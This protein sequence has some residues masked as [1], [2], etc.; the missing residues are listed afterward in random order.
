MIVDIKLS[1][2]FNLSELVFSPEAVRLGIDNST[3]DPA[4]IDKLKL[5]SLDVLQVARD[6]Y[7]TPFSPNSGY[8]CKELNEAIKGSKASQHMRGEAVDF[9]VPG[10]ST[11]DLALWIK[12]KSGIKYDQL[13][14]ENYSKELR[15]SGWVHCSIAVGRKAR[16]QVLTKLV[17]DKTYYTG[18]IY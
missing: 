10:V 6:H 3:H 12:E 18:L 9:N 7:K 17:G 4:I 5:V 15:R 8:R 16:G 11:Y 1:R 13:I 2:N 14:L